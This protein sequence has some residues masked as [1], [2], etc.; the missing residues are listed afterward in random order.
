MAEGFDGLS[1]TED[2]N[3]ALL[4]DSPS[5]DAGD[6][7]FSDSPDLGDLDSSF[8]T[9]CARTDMGAFEFGFGDF[10]CDRAVDITDFRSWSTCMSNPPGV[11]YPAGCEAFDKNMDDRVDMIDFAVFLTALE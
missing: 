6:P 1:G 4:P 11:G 2:D 10:N 8:R 5:I 9:R 7:T 3:L